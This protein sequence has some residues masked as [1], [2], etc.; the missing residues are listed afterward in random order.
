MGALGITDVVSLRFRE[1]V[2]RFF[3]GLVLVVLNI[4]G[5][6]AGSWGSSFV[7][8]GMVI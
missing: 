5:W 7:R 2:L 3:K 1:K 4:L 8:A 6:L